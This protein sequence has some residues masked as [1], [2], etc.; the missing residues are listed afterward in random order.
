MALVAEP[1]EIRPIEGAGES[2]DRELED[3]V[4]VC[5]RHHAPVVHALPAYR[6]FAEHLG[7]DTAPCLTG[8]ELPCIG[9]GAVGAVRL[10]MPRAR[11]RG[12]PGR[13]AWMETRHLRDP[14]RPHLEGAFL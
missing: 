9:A 3:V 6:L 1:L 13:V 2:D 12:A 8:V 5:G 7:A 10:A 11:Q 14:P 4:A